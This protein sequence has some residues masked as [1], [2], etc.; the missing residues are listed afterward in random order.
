MYR[1]RNV[2]EFDKIY[3]RKECAGY[4]NMKYVLEIMTAGS[5]Y[6]KGVWWV[7]QQGSMCWRG[8]VEISRKYLQERS[9]VGLRA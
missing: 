4:D 9:V 5:M 7:S 1:K 3:F 2:D 6:R 8:V